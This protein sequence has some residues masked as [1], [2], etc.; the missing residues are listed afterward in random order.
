MKHCLLEN[1]KTNTRFMFA[2]CELLSSTELKKINFNNAH[3][4]D[5][6]SMFYNCKALNSFEITFDTSQVTDMENLF[7]ECTLLNSLQLNKVYY[8]NG[9]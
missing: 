8:L 1:V 5:M 6:N 2:N 4:V 3:L 9:L 7:A